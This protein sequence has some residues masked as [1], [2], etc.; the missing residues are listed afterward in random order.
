MWGN[1]VY[2]VHLH[3]C[4]HFYGDSSLLTSMTQPAVRRLTPVKAL[5]EW[6]EPLMPRVTLLVLTQNR[7]HTNA[8]TMEWMIWSWEGNHT[9]PWQGGR[10]YWL[11]ANQWRCIGSCHISAE[12]LYV[13]EKVLSFKMSGLTSKS[14]KN[15]LHK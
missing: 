10:V 2:V 14:V 6:S 5:L 8:Y 9:P 1:K 15:W 3:N 11:L 13:V 7:C 12:C 4:F